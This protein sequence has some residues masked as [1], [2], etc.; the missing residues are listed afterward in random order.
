MRTC[1][2]RLPSSEKGPRG[3]VVL[4]SA[5]NLRKKVRD[6]PT[7]TNKLVKEP[8]ASR[9]ERVFLVG[10]ALGGGPSTKLQVFTVQRLNMVLSDS[11]MALAL[12]ELLEGRIVFMPRSLQRVPFEV[13]C[14]EERFALRRQRSLLEA[15]ALG[16]GPSTK[17]V[18][19]EKT[20]PYG[21]WV[22]CAG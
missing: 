14:V 6:L 10:L 19:E 5:R 20:L 7:P 17:G 16:I 4:G 11:A 13:H 12:C 9:V 2:T 18:L 3:D 8:L 22:W 21:L 1:V 15:F